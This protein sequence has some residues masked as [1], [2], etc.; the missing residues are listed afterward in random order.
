MPPYHP[1]FW[2]DTL[3]DRVELVLG[4]VG[5]TTAV[6]SAFTYRRNSKEARAKWLSEMYHR[7]NGNPDMR[8]VRMGL[9]RDGAAFAKAFQLNDE[10]R[11]RADDYLSFFEL[12]GYLYHEKLLNR[13][14]IRMFNEPLKDVA[15]RPE[16]TRQ[17]VA[18]GFKQ[19][20]YPLKELGLTKNLQLE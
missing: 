13:G 7:Y 14:D 4:V 10:A 8:L 15:K 19:L 3:K 2:P 17:L 6:I 16:I 11:G 1:A 20:A 18:W 9:N 12:V 5:I